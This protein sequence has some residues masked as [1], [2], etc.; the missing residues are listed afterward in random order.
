MGSRIL[1]SYCSNTPGGRILW[2]FVRILRKVNPSHIYRGG[3]R[4]ETLIHFFSKMPPPF[5][6]P[7]PLSRPRG[8]FHHPNTQIFQ[9]Y[10]GRTISSPKTP[11][12]HRIQRFLPVQRFSRYSNFKSPDLPMWLVLV[13]MSWG[14]VSTHI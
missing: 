9:I 13:N 4:L 2:T 3:G 5:S 1:R 8:D 12:I 7:L 14:I 10:K 11:G 6:S